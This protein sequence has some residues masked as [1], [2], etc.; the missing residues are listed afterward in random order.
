MIHID[1]YKVI[2][3]YLKIIHKNL[4]IKIYRTRIIQIFNNNMM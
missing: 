2:K 3:I 4:K 1:K